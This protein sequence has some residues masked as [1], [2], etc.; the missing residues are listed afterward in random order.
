MKKRISEL[1]KTLFCKHFVGGGEL[2]TLVLLGMVAAASYLVTGGLLPEIEQNPVNPEHV[3]IDNTGVNAD[4]D[5]LQL[6]NLQPI[7]TPS[8][9][10]FGN[11]SGTPPPGSGT[12]GAGTP[13]PT[14]PVAACLNKAAVAI[15]VDTSGS[16]VEVDPGYSISRIARLKDALKEFLTFF[17]PDSVVSLIEFANS[18]KVLVPFGKKSQN[19]TILSV[20]IDGI[21][22]GGSTNMRDGLEKAIEQ[23][24][25]AKTTYPNYNQFTVFMSDGLPESGFCKYRQYNPPDYN[26]GPYHYYQR[27]LDPSDPQFVVPPLCVIEGTS[28]EPTFLTHIWSPI[29]PATGITPADDIKKTGKLF[30]LSMREIPKNDGDYVY[31]K[32]KYDKTEELM[33]A[34]ASEPKSTYYIDSPTTEDLTEAYKKIAAKICP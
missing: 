3:Q 20:A 25:A 34:V 33:K 14:L 29:S 26:T 27:S 5:T 1:V 16:M 19:E 30:S 18:G 31:E 9:T 12:P 8:P 23:L 13:T 22:S 21:V 6:I 4:R 2:Y 15:V 11:F 10:P 32:D 24:D 17:K 28:L 7:S